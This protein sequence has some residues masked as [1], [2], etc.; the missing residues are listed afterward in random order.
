[1]SEQYSHGKYNLAAEFVF[2]DTF[3]VARISRYPIS[4]NERQVMESE[5]ATMKFVA[6]QTSLPVP[7]VYAYDTSL[8][9]PF[10]APFI[11]ME[12]VEGWQPIFGTPCLPPYAIKTNP[13]NG[14]VPTGA[15][16]DQIR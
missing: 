15:R 16:K 11:L 10:E 4:N 9:N 5:I 13:T 1:M 7:E 14:C 8:D 12:G 3:C 2:P 6:G